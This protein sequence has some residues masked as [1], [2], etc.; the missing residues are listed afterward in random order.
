MENYKT[1]VMISLPAT[2]PL[3]TA[4]D[5]D[6]CID[7]YLSESV[8]GIITVSESSR[9][10]YFNMISRE[11]DGSSKVVCKTNKNIFRRQ[12]APKVYD[13]NTVCF[14]V[15]PSFIM[16]TNSLMAGKLKSVIIPRERSIDIDDLLDFKMAELLI[17]ES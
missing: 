8:D 4:G 15:N 1:D 7:L 5:V 13:M 2:S 3:R 16:S 14:T 17:S 6:K 12:D 9:N 11:I 10:P